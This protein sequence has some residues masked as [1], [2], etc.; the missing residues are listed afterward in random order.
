MVRRRDGGY[1]LACRLPKGIQLSSSP[2]R[3]AAYAS[4][5]AIIMISSEHSGNDRAFPACV[6]NLQDLIQARSEPRRH[7]IVEARY[8]AYHPSTSWTTHRW[9][10]FLLLD[11]RVRGSRTIAPLYLNRKG[12]TETSGVLSVACFTLNSISFSALVS[13]TVTDSIPLQVTSRVALSFDF[14]SIVSPNL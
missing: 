10:C 4:A 3:K 8:P 12:L 1:R 5:A 7:T 9:V 14:M 2:T 13:K 6:T 11:P